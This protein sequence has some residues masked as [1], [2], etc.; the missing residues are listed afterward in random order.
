MSSYWVCGRV[1]DILSK[2]LPVQFFIRHYFLFFGVFFLNIVS[3]GILSFGVSSS[4][5][6][7]KIAFNIFYP[8]LRL[9]NWV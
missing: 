7:K 8:T 2:A 1:L 9:K 6:V 5:N 4:S 3:F